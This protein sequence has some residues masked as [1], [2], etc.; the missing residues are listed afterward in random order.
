MRNNN[1]SLEN[2][3]NLNTNY[4]EMERE[5]D[6][7]RTQVDNQANQY[8]GQL[9]NLQSIIDTQKRELALRNQRQAEQAK[10]VQEK[11][12]FQKE[13]D[14]R[15]AALRRQNDLQ[16]RLRQVVQ[17]QRTPHRIQELTDAWHLIILLNS[18]RNSG[19][20]P[21]LSYLQQESKTVQQ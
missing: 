12:S 21:M 5:R 15:Q 13:R 19:Q 1:I 8:Q 2:L 11:G 6:N 9:N 10:T 18:I 14:E 4:Q 7:Y 3:A 17:N 20:G 16:A